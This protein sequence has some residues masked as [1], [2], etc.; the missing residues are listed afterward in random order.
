M[1]HAEIQVDADAGRAV[2]AGFP[3]VNRDQVGSRLR[4][5]PNGA[6]VD[7]QDG[8]GFAGRGLYDETSPAAVRILT[9]DKKQ[10]LDATFWRGAMDR[11]LDLRRTLVNLS[12]TDAWRVVNGAGDGLPGLVVET[13]S[14]YAVLRLESEALRPHL[15]AIIDAVRMT[16]QPRGLYEKR[17]GPEGGRGHHL[18]GST[19]PDALPVREGTLR[20]LVRLSEGEKTGFYL[21][22]R[23]A[24]R[25]LARYARG[26]QVV[27]AYSFSGTLSLTAAAA[28]S[29]R[30]VSVDPTPRSTAWGRE[31]FAAN[32]LPPESHEFLTGDPCEV[33]GR[34]SSGT[35]RFD[36]ALVE[37]PWFDGRPAPTPPSSAKGKPAKKGSH[38]AKPA[39]TS[40]AKK[41][42]SR[43]AK[44]HGK[45]HMGAAGGPSDPMEI[46][47]RGYANLVKAAVGVL[48]PNGILACTLHQKD[49]AYADFLD[50][51]GSA[52]AEAG[53]RLQVLE[54]HGLPADFPVHPSCPRDQ[55][56]K[57]VVCAVRR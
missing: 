4:G 46:F 14:S 41:P 45:R 28:G 54:V 40:A 17:R 27:N 42:A 31:N 22:M 55:Y 7:V 29:P 44:K 43:S 50:V 21:D 1:M 34:L 37:A 9:R 5:L 23:E 10:A 20:Y 16:L 18:G 19:A 12:F 38:S 48:Q 32:G 53:A 36:V 51:L 39:K 33:L 52:S 35:R 26:R 13:Y 25:V 49:M 2:R 24:R 56:L 11:A 47:R 30:V 57:F 6:V 3:L 8:R 15:S